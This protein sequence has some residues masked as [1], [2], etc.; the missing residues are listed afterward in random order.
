MMLELDAIDTVASL[1]RIS[2]FSREPKF[3]T[4]LRAAP[5]QAKL[6]GALK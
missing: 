3:S 6:A 1:A 4:R 5:P 2:H